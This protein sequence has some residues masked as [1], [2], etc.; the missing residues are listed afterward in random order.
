[1]LEGLIG[2]RAVDIVV[3]QERLRKADVPV[4][5]GDA[6]YAEGL[7]WAPRISIE[8]MLEALLESYSSRTSILPSPSVS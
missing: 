8:A 2:D 4:L 3:E 7:G 6:S 1:M 5:Y